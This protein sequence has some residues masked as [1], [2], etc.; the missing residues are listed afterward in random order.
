VVSNL[1]IGVVTPPVG[2]T[3]FVAAGVGH[4]QPS[5][6]VRYILPFLAVMMVVQLLVTFVPAIT[7]TLPGL[8]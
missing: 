3:L 5:V 2:T 4:V 1:I 8:M 7:T 6:V